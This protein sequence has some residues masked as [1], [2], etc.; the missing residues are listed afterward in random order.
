MTVHETT[1]LTR[2]CSPPRQAREKPPAVSA[3]LAASSSW[4]RRWRNCLLRDP[5]ILGVQHEGVTP[6]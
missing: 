4:W 2:T 3:S 5:S 6:R 1:H